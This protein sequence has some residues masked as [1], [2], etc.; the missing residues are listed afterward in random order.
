ML[1]NMYTHTLL[2]FQIDRLRAQLHERKHLVHFNKPMRLP[3]DPHCQVTGIV[4]EEASLFKSALVPAK[5]TFR[6]IKGDNYSVS[7]VIF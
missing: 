3:L 5:L 6:T 1:I 7:Y 2:L 4:P